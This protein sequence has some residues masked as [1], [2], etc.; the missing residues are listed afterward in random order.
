MP[1]AVPNGMSSRLKHPR[2][3]ASV[4]AQGCRSNSPQPATKDAGYLAGLFDNYRNFDLNSPSYDEKYIMPVGRP[5]T[6]PAQHGLLHQRS[7]AQ[8]DF[9]GYHR[10]PAAGGMLRPAASADS[11]RNAR[12]KVEH[13]AGRHQRKARA[14]R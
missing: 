5:E 11:H 10:R 3:M 4:R 6:V 12:A 1:K 9:P 7:E 14:G 2:T 8:H 13:H